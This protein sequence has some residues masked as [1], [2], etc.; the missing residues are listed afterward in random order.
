MYCKNCGKE[1]AADAKFCMQCGTPV[2]DVPAPVQTAPVQHT[3]EKAE[4][5]KA[6]QPKAEPVDAPRERPVFDE[7]KWNVSEYPDQNAV[8]KTEE[9]DFNWNTEP[10]AAP[11]PKAEAPAAVRSETASK[12]PEH[13]EIPEASKAQSVPQNNTED[14]VLSGK[15]LDSAIFGEKE[16]KKAP[17]S[18]SAAE[19]IDKFY[20][21]NKKNE[22]FQQ[23][24][25][26]EYNKVKGGN[27]IEQEIS[28]AE[29]RASQRFES[30]KRPENST[31][32]EFLESEGIVKPYQPKA[33]E[34]D[35]LERIEAQE[36]EKE[37]KRL[38]E[39]ARLA[40]IEEARHEAEVK[41]L[42]EEEERLKAEAEARR[43]EE[44]AKMKAAEEARLAEEARRKA[45]EEA[46]RRA[47]EEARRKAEEEARIKAEEERRRAETEARVKAEEEARLRAEAD[48]KAAQEAAKI[49]AQQE[50]RLAAEA[51]AQYKAEQ[52]RRRL[53]DVEAQRK[54]EE[55]RKRLEEQANE[56]VAKEEVRKVLEQ[57]ARMREEEA[58]KIKAA[59]AG[60]RADAAAERQAAQNLVRKDVED[61][62]RA[63]RNQINE[64][65]RSRSIAYI[66]SITY[67]RTSGDGKRHDALKRYEQNADCRQGCDH[68]RTKR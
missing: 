46:K 17:E 19:R 59:V 34:S 26:K 58:A 12:A 2:D 51:E 24:L 67:R 10:V 64:M 31:M 8:E 4:P 33:F 61:A 52:E 3:T 56:A 30:S 36:A 25:N 21:F 27:A 38:E 16:P 40:A 63:T 62:H 60:L 6:P 54:L 45:E 66:R 37:A 29:E 9:I 48:L 55:E 5:A 11:Q 53:A 50:A 35:V 23:L 42:K 41:R 43:L 47:E 14:H 1:L 68:R 7:I 39:E 65:A 57:T 20:T 49:R 13:R 28:Q 15:D 18:M 32:E 22:E 44:I